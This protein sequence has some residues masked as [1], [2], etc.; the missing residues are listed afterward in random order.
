MKRRSDG[1]GSIYPAGNGWTAEISLGYD[2]RTGRRQ[3]KRVH[4]RTKKEAVTRLHTLMRAYAPACAEEIT[5]TDWLNRWTVT[6]REKLRANT[7][8]DYRRYLEAATK[9]IGHIRLKDLTAKHLQRILDARWGSHHRAAEMFRTVMAMVLEKAVRDGLITENPAQ[10]L[11][12]PRKPRRR[13]FISPAHEEWQRLI[14]ADT[15][16]YCWRMI[17]LTELVTGLRR[18]E[19]L[20]LNWSDFSETGAGGTLSIKRAVIIGEQGNTRPLIMADTKTEASQRLLPLPQGYMQ[21]LTAYRKMQKM[22]L[23]IRRW[24]HPEMVFT[25]QKGNPI[26]PDTFSSMYYRTRKRLRISATFHQLRHDMATSM[27]EAGIFD[28]KDMQSQLGHSSIKITLDTYTHTGNMSR[29]KVE[30]WLGE[31]MR[32]AASTA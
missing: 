11:I 19:I 22:I 10:R 32:T 5:L 2:S 25:D 26:N 15:G 28:V 12:L 13:P 16:L 3:R 9:E 27:K 8:R 20:A 18:S 30:S 7:M 17:L 23:R 14:T 4:A 1:E 29:K 6:A 31:R 24:L 21:E